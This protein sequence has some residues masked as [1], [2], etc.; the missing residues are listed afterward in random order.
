MAFSAFYCSYVKKFKKGNIDYIFFNYNRKTIHRYKHKKK[1]NDIYA[2]R[3]NY[4]LS[5]RSFIT[6]KSEVK[7]HILA[8]FKCE[9]ATK[10]VWLLPFNYISYFKLIDQ[11]IIKIY[12]KKSSID[13][14]RNNLIYISFDVNQTIH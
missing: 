14:K 10:Q 1:E 13:E 6:K 9:G 3:W 11:F 8:E 2:S 4:F 5:Q 7:E 12:L